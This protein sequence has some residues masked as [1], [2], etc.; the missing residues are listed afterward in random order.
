MKRSILTATIALSMSVSSLTAQQSHES[1]GSADASVPVL[2]VIDFPT[3]ASAQSHDAFVRGVLL[4]HNFHYGPAAQSFREA[5]RLDSTDVMGYWGEAMA[6]THPV[7]NQQDTA[8]ARAVLRRL[9][10]TREARLAMA[11]TPRERQWLEAVET[12]YRME[13]TKAQRDTAYSLAMEKLH[14]SDTAD[15]EATTFYALSLLGLNQGD[16]DAATYRKAYELV[17][18]VFKTHPRHPGAAHYLIHAVDDPEHAGLGLDAANAYSQIAPSAGHA[19]HMTSHVFLALGKWDDVVSA[20]LRANATLPKGVL[21]GH[22]VHWL[23]Y[24]LIQQGRYHEADRWLDSTAKQS[25]SGPPGAREDLAEAAGLMA[26]ANIADTH[27]WNGRA[28]S[29]RLDQKVFN[30]DSYLEAISSVAAAE[31]GYAL[32]ALNRGDLKTFEDI[33][34]GMEKQR[35][36]AATDPNKAT[37]RG[38]SE[39]MEKTLKAYGM[40]KRGN[41]DGALALFQDAASEEASLPM[42]FGPPVTIKPPREAAAE[43]LLEMKRPN[44]A[45]AEFTLA[46]ARTPRRVAP[47][48]GLARAEKALGNRDASRKLYA[49]VLSIWHAADPD[50]PELAEVRAGSR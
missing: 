26:A 18:P 33:L 5:Q 46:L 13:G 41:R 35:L 42:P 30:P 44:D 36:Q 16:R 31:F 39:V 48:L 8:E 49:E 45:K 12:L 4:M 21:V 14:A 23:H 24:G 22:G 17:A 11:R 9:A 43:L 2:G 34:A 19:I 47:L 27:R 40:M 6:Y 28:A 32:A 7:W 38:M 25:E 10:P 37:S 20:N 3:S 1:H 29:I 15:I 50:I